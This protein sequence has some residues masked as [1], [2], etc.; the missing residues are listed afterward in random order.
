MLA[1][2]VSDLAQQVIF[3]LGL[4]AIYGLVAIG[5]S[6]IYRSMGLLSFVHPQYVMLGSVFGY[7]ALVTL[8][9]PLWAAVVPVG[10]GT[11][12]V[13]LAI[14]QFGL[15]PI[16]HRKGTEVSMILATVGWGIVLVEVARLV[17][18]SDAL[19]LRSGARSP[20]QVLGVEIRWD[21]VAILVTGTLLVVA[22]TLFL[23]VTRTGRAVRAVGEN[24][25]T[26][27]LMGIDV[28]RM[29]GVSA[30]ISGLL[31]GIA[32]LLV[33]YLFVGGTS[34]GVIGLKSLAAAVLGGFG[35]LPGALVGGLLVGVL[36]NLVAADV[37]SNWR[38]AIVFGL[39]IAVLLVRPS[40]IFGRRRLFRS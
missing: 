36:D 23:R 4:G 13:S 30:A 40:G 20:F 9:L 2:A 29:F 19:A 33:G 22:L 31:G 6:L 26:A 3:G 34:T 14:D 1:T 39:V 27:A 10:L 35:N 12:I 16:R 38:D 11:A 21:T 8:G 7:T 37:S 17:Y 15:R 25:S 18:G 32:G 5:F 28:E 24:T